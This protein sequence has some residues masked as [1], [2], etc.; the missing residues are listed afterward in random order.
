MA[1]TRLNPGWNRRPLRQPSIDEHFLICL[2]GKRPSVNRRGEG[3]FRVVGS[4]KESIGPQRTNTRN[5]QTVGPPEF[6]FNRPLAEPT[7]RAKSRNTPLYPGLQPPDIG[8]RS[9]GQT[10]SRS[11]WRCAPHSTNCVLPVERNVAGGAPTESRWSRRVKR[12]AASIGPDSS[13][14]ACHHRRALRG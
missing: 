4:G 13:L 2:P 5:F 3:D 1:G 8:R 7:T 9:C 11:S 6:I 12:P 14:R 10:G